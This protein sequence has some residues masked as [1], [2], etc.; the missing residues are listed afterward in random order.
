MRR[1]SSIL[2][3]CVLLS[4]GVSL[5]VGA[6]DV[7]ETACDESEGLPYKGTPL[8][9]I[10]PLAVDRA[11]HSSLSSLHLKNGVPSLF[12]PTRVSDTDAKRATDARV[13]L[14]L[15]CTLLC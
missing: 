9:R 3:L 11:L 7:M 14:A 8:F 1:S 15:V 4:F 2:V 12:A 5:A 6:E 10:L 13:S